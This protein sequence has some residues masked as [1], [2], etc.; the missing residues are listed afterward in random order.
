MAPRAARA[1]SGCVAR[2]ELCNLNVTSTIE[3]PNLDVAIDVVLVGDGFTTA[4]DWAP[5]AAAAI[6]QFQSAPANMYGRFPGTFNFHVVDVISATTD[7]SDTDPADTAL[8]MQ[9][10]GATI[11]ADAARV[12]LAA[13]NAPD[14]DV[15][16]AIA[17]ATS[18]RANAN[19]NSQLASGGMVRM[20]RGGDVITHE[21]GHA[22]FHLADEYVEAS[23]CGT[24]SEA[25]LLREA[26]VTADPTCFKFQGISGATCVQGG[27]YCAA[28]VYRSASTCLMRTNTGAACPACAREID[29]VLRERRSR[30]DWAPPWVATTAPAEGS[31]VS[32]VASLTAQG[33][34]DWF[35]PTTFAFELD[36]AYVGAAQGGTSGRITLDS[37]RLPDGP[38]TLSVYG[39]DARGFSAP[40]RTIGFTSRNADDTTAP[41][42]AITTPADGAIV[43]GMVSVVVQATGDTGDLR[44]LALWIDGAPVLAAAGR[45][46]LFYLWDVDAAGL[47]AHQLTARG[48]DYAENVGASPVITVTATTVAGGQ[49]VNPPSIVRPQDGS[50]VG[51]WFIL[52][53]QGE[54]SGGVQG[55]G[56]LDVALILDNVPV[57]PNPLQGGER[58]AVLD[59]RGWSPGPHQLRLRAVVGQAVVE[60]DPVLVVRGTPTAPEAFIRS[61]EAYSTVRGTVSVAL[62][63][64]DDVNLAS[65]T[66]EVDGAPAGSV[67]GGVG[68]VAWPT[69]GLSG[70]R[71]LRAVALSTDGGVGRSEGTSVC[72]DNSAPAVAIAWPHPGDVVA[73]GAQVVRADISEVG[74]SVS[75]VELLVDGAVVASTTDSGSTAA[76]VAE[77]L[78]G[79]HTLV[80]RATDRAGNVGSSSPVA[81][82][83]QACLAGGCDD[84][85]ACTVDRCG[86]SGSCVHSAIAGCCATA[87]DC[88]DGDA[89]TTDTCV[90][91]A[92]SHAAAASCC[93]HASQCED[94]DRCTGDFCSGPGGVCSHAPAGCCASTAECDDGNAC[95]VDACVGAPSGFCAHDWTP[96]CCSVDADCDDGLACTTDTCSNG[97]CTSAPVAGCC[98]S[99][100]EC[101]DADSCTQDLCVSNTC[102]NR[103]IAGCCAVDADCQTLNAC[104]TGSC[105]RSRCTFTVAPG[106]CNFDFECEDADPCTVHAC[107][108][109][110]CTL[111]SPT[112]G[113]ADAGVPDA[114]APDAAL[115]P[116]A[117]PADGGVGID[118]GQNDAAVVVD[119]GA[120]DAAVEDGGDEDAALADAAEPLDAAPTDAA[121]AQDAAPADAAPTDA[122]QPDGAATDAAPV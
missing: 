29:D 2:P 113:C 101:A 52:E 48:T 99:S 57:V 55:G 34:D 81:I 51:P 47:G 85:D 43:S 60:S 112:A 88:Q 44:D 16:V 86:A 53:W 10:G 32:G 7:V 121:E 33:H 96:G 36:G 31:V 49:P 54:G 50:L 89:C 95:T 41:T 59:A 37:T 91:G 108:N 90:N 83:A 24:P 69:A 106:C 40:A 1:Q 74:S 14:V 115:G 76:L 23:R 20:R 82:T 105:V 117:G 18:G 71:T 100:T 94:A 77:L 118:A 116:D 120:E 9:V 22:L 62:A 80:V 58:S 17:N 102:E 110:A 4:A 98:E 67:S 87:A 3:Q 72:I 42:V 25:G 107:S 61:P 11:V 84:G 104:A 97:T 46:S 119:G 27:K 12:N 21:L 70:C 30:V 68:T 35:T 6:A 65:L 103:P 122:A 5:V 66:L 92:C 111:V 38:H 56:A 19:Y 75:R 109:N 93:N 28:G 8:G 79:P 78:P 39:A 114:A 15:V 73:P 13:L 63:G 26:N 45:T 64:A